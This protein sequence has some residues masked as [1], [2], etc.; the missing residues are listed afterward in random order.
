ML[1]YVKHTQSAHI[2]AGP[3]STTDNSVFVLV[4]DIYIRVCLQITLQ[5]GERKRPHHNTALKKT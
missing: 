5:Q 2:G 3:C 4:N 1:I